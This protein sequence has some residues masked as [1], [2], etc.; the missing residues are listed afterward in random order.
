MNF[1]FLNKINSLNFMNTYDFFPKFSYNFE[2][3]NFHFCRVYLYIYKTTST[4]KKF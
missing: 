2:F 4:C 1:F 3:L